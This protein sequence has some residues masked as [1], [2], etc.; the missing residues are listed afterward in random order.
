MREAAET[1]GLSLLCA[2]SSPGLQLRLLVEERE[3]R[4]KLVDEIRLR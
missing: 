2:S 3:T 1:H 4:E